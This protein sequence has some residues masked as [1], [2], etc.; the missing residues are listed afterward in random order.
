MKRLLPLLALIATP[1]LAKEPSA[2]AVRGFAFARIHC[3]ACHGIT[4]NSSSPN[5]EA[6]VWEDVANRPGTTRGSLHKFLRDSHNYP[7]AM[8]FKVEPRHIHDLAAYLITLKRP[9]YHPGI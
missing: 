7:E 1:A 5:P 2:S 8:Q 6:P 3:A 9:G 4:P